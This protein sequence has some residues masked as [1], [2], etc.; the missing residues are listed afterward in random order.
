MILSMQFPESKSR[1]LLWLIGIFQMKPLKFYHFEIDD[2]DSWRSIENHLPQW[3]ASTTKNNILEWL[4]YLTIS[5][6]KFE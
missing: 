4:P 1:G 5:I 2:F 6:S 3:I